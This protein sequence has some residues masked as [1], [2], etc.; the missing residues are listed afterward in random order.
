MKRGLQFAGW[1]MALAMGT[2]MAVP[3]FAQG[4]RANWAQNRQDNKPPKQQRQQQ[5]RQERRQQKQESRRAP[6][7]RQNSGGNRTPSPNVS[8]ADMM[9]QPN[10]NPNRPP[11]AYT[12]PPKK[13][14]NS[15]SPQERRKVLDNNRRLQSLPP[16]QRQELQER[17]QVWNRLTP[18]QRQHI[19][20]DVLPKWQQMP[21]DRRQ[22][23]QQ[24]LRVLQNMPEAARN[25]RLN[26][27]NFTKGMSDE[28]RA[29]L[30]DLSHLHVGGTPEPP[31]E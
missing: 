21:P 18:Q 23:I 10:V 16:A 19:R 2:A 30:H 8:R 5:Q 1:L 4:P 22:A 6:I 11:S 25:Q 17:A 9:G 15:L 29:T 24:R 13:E 14:F 26:D 28:D 3:S 12:P 20:N 7:E 31:N 27:P